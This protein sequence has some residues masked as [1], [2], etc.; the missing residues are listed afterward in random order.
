LEAIPED[1]FDYSIRTTLRD[2]EE[3]LDVANISVD[4]CRCDATELGDVKEQPS[5]V[6]LRTFVVPGS[7]R[8]SASGF[9]ECDIRILWRCARNNILQP[10]SG[11]IVVNFV[12][13]IHRH[14]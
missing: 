10:P 2:L 3:S 7:H 5:L 1:D 8:T 6:E 12:V 4:G 9:E 13:A 14:R 11:G